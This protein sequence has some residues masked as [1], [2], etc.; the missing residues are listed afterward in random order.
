M[1]DRR[2]LKPVLLVGVGL[3]IWEALMVLAWFVLGIIIW[4]DCSQ[5]TELLKEHRHAGSHARTGICICLALEHY[6]AY[7]RIIASR[8]THDSK[9]RNDTWN[10]IP[11]VPYLA[12]WAFAM[13][14]TLGT[15]IAG[16]T[17]A[18][19]IHI[20]AGYQLKFLRAWMIA[21]LIGTSLV[22]PW[23]VWLLFSYGR[24]RKV[25]EKKEE[26][27]REQEEEET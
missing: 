7:R 8:K 4:T 10:S 16:L 17:A 24:H 11:P 2:T 5:L 22:F 9:T 12:S 27:E 13:A 3:A 26:N 14:Y 21:A 15:D 1:G 20:S 19:C 25:S 23:S 6:K 18:Y